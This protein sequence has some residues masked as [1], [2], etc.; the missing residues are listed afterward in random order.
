MYKKA[1]ILKLRFATLVGLLMLEQLFD[2]PI[3]NEK[4]FREDEE[5]LDKLA[6]RLEEE[7]K[8]SGKKSYLTKKT[9]KDKELKLKWDIVVD[10]L[11]TKLE[12][13]EAESTAKENKEHNQ[14]IDELIA[15]KKEEELKGKSIKEL[16]KMRR[17]V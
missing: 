1:I 6:V 8:A 9:A 16:E 17:K 11:N 7:Y 14:K 15:E 12:V 3:G 4:E 2:L 5:T 10:I 13:Q